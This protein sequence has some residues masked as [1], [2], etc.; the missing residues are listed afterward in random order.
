MPE[1]ARCRTIVAAVIAL[2]C[3]GCGQKGA[4]YLP[5]AESEIITRPTQTPA[6]ASNTDLAGTQWQVVTVNGNPV[7]PA[8]DD[9]PATVEF[10][11]A[12]R[13]AFTGGCNRYAGEYSMVGTEDLRF[14]ANFASTR[15]A[16]APAL[17][18]QDEALAAALGAAARLRRTTDELVIVA[19]D[20]TELV[21]LRRQASS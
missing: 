14:D 21:T 3:A 10:V 17:M 16:C 6:T 2:A 15:K 4:L 7:A 1:A 13:V 5:T 8:G 11:D 20:G 18:Q 12:T 9:T 19:A